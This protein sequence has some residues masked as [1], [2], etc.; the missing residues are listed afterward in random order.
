[1]SQETIISALDTNHIDKLCPNCG[2]VGLLPC[3]D[4]KQVPAHSCLLMSSRDEAL[5]YPRGHLYLG[6]C[7]GCGFLCN[8]DYNP[9]FQSYSPNYEET[10]HFSECFSAFA[11]RL[12]QRWV[13]QYQL[14][15]KTILEIGCGKGQFLD[16]M[17]ELGNNRGIGIDPACRPERLSL[18]AKSRVTFIQDY[19]DESYTHLTADVICCRH[20]LEH[21]HETQEFLSSVRRTIGDRL[22]TLMLFE[23]P[24]VTRVLREYAFWDLYY[25]HCSYFTAGS[26]ARLFRLCGF[27][28]LELE[29]DFDDQYLIL[30][31]RPVNQP[32]ASE[33]ELEDDLKLTRQDVMAFRDGHKKAI[34]SWRLKV[35]SLAKTGR[36]IAWG[37]G[38]KCVAFFTTLGIQDEIE[39]VVDINP[40]KHGKFLPG[41]GHEVISPERLRDYQ[42]DHV[43]VM[44]PIYCSEISQTLA[45][46]N[47]NASLIPVC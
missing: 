4:L 30:A 37:G 36:V 38:S 42:P 23:L 12:A 21:I 18:E 8:A 31:A 2:A 41:T 40:F 9:T 1:M 24:D 13:D 15:A 43:L 27:D 46:L 26:L 33:L 25:E 19:Y 5:E 44:N 7:E 35:Q 10:Q 14:H 34:Q 32:T 17:C 22:D 28:L 16:L 6:F 11:R 20:T 47:V 29:R 45:A 39:Y 3:F